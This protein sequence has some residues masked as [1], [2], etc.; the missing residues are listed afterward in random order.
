MRLTLHNNA[1][2]RS[3][4]FA[5]FFIAIQ[6]APYEKNRAYDV[7]TL[8]DDEAIIYDWLNFKFLFCTIDA[9]GSCC[10]CDLAFKVASAADNLQL[11]LRQRYDN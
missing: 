6:L 9:A 2:G 8:N 5:L 10:R 1:K 4:S 7:M 11:N 3:V